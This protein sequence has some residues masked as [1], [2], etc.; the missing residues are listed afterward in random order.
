[1]LLISVIGG[2]VIAYFRKGIFRFLRRLEKLVR[3]KCADRRFERRYVK[4]MASEFEKV[5]L[6]GVLPARPGREPR[7]SEVFVLPAFSEEYSWEGRNFYREGGLRP[8][9]PEEWIIKWIRMPEETRPVPLPEA[10]RRRTLVLLGDPGAGKTTLL[11]YMALAH[12][13]ALTGDASLLRQIDPRPER[14][15][16]VFLPLREAAAA[17]STLTTYAEEY[18]R[19]QTQRT[20]DPPPGYFE[21]Q[22][23]RGRCL[24][25]LDGL[26]EVLGR[27]DEPYRRIC[28]AVIALAAVEEKNP[29]IL[30][31]RIAGW[32][33]TLSPNFSIL[34]IAPFDPPRREEFIR[35]W[36]QAVE[37]SAVEGK[38]SPDQTEIRRGRARERAR[39]LIGAVEGN[40]RLQRL[41]TNPMLLSVMA[42]VHRVDVTLPRDR[43]TLYR[44]LT[45]LLLERWD[46][47]R[48]I[49]DQGTGL[50]L[51]QKESL[52]RQI[53]YQFHERG[54]RFLPAGKWSGS[55]PMRSLP[56]VNPR[57]EPGSSWTG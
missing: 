6:I 2:V 24:F 51:H 20:L 26:D 1:M 46:V 47:G 23:R 39:D 16:P 54:V 31:S 8:P 11:R 38:E 28:T 44:R 50:T 43:A 12:A 19:R 52:M 14:R 34:T 55:S 13:R 21:R 45:E 15:L 5:S 27:G 25:L 33:G 9:A 29:F 53:G 37:A 42:M 49:E 22:A 18:V 10:L 3:Q 7:L 48:G 41:A 32:R 57:N 17:E 56:W 36:Y 35:R 40:D 4:W 30:T